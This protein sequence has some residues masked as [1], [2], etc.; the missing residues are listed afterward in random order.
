MITT[1]PYPK[2]LTGPCYVTDLA[3]LR[4][5]L[6][7]AECDGTT[8]GQ[9]WS[10]VRRRAQAAPE[11]YPWF[12][13]FVALVTG[14]EQD[15]ESA[16]RVIRDYVATFDAQGFGMG[17]Q[18]HF[19]CFAFP[20]AR[21]SLYFQWLQSLNA[22]APAEADAIQA[23]LLDFQYVNFFYGMRTKP[24]PECVDNQ[25]MSLCY[26]NALLGHLFGASSA[27]AR[28]IMRDGLRR[29]PDVIGGIPPSG[30]T[31]EGSTYMDH[32][33]GPSIPFVVELLEAAEGGDWFSRALPPH[34]GSAEAVAR[35]IARE[36]MP[37]GLYLPWDH[38]GYGWPTRSCIAYGAHRTGDPLFLTLL[39]RAN[40]S[41]DSSVGWGF[42][43]LIWALTWWPETRTS[44][45]EACAASWCAPEEGA[46]L[47]SR[48]RELYL[49]QMWDAAAP[50]PIRAHV[51][52]NALVLSAYG[53][54][55]T[56]DG[57][58]EKSCTAFH[59]DDTWIALKNMTFTTQRSNYGI[60]CA[61]GHGVLL[62][63]GWESMRPM[64]DYPQARLLDYD[65]TVPTVATDVTP[66]Y[67]ERW[68]D[69]RRVAR[70]ST[71]VDD[72][73]WL[74][75]DLAAFADEHEVVS[76][77]YLRPD[78]QPADRGVVIKTAEGVRLHLWP[79]LGPDAHTVVP[80][81]G[82]PERLDGASLQVDFRQR[83]RA[84]RWLW[85]AWPEHTRRVA[86]D[87][88]DG[89]QVA[90]D[91]GAVFSDAEGAAQA[92][93]AS[94]ILPFIKPAFMLSALPAERRWW[95][96]REITAPGGAWWLRLP[97]L[98]FNP[99]L[100]VNGEPVDLAP[101]AQ[102]MELLEPQVPMP[103]LPA[104]TSVEV[105]VRVDCGVGQYGPD[106]HDGTGFAG[107]PA[108]LVPAKADRLLH[109][110]YRDGLVMIC[111]D[112]RDWTLPYAL[113]PEEDAHV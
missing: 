94:L 71:L 55:L 2:A 100:W 34:G 9:V 77:W 91:P 10:S 39:E 67:S 74:I 19:W 99:A 102:S 89:W 54:P 36:W 12:C 53:S 108:V 3:A 44:P 25:T 52:P 65:E 106:S 42:D 56:I 103:A 37:N 35:M 47:V 82:Y 76:R 98:M 92:R 109:A 81:P 107:H 72:R 113:L 38:Y 20:H 40:W 63:D 30:Y 43:D 41:K 112:T 27:I 88:A 46:A 32:V 5:K 104:G 16:R 50:T 110:A 93:N 11:R 58:A 69:T 95:Y 111:T 90:A 15:L 45:H 84:C 8:M 14:A 85:L 61:G 13:P 49:M 28:R 96:R 48:D 33:V 59:Y 68:P 87:C 101:F 79:L 60:G 29:L 97:C 75:E 31:G 23:A 80:V 51:N 24:E 73:F 62:V 64:S 57:V 78:A 18:F 86:L 70:R 7:R 83:G 6:A 4:E 22:W 21:W 17:L 105:V 66:I 26:S 1:A